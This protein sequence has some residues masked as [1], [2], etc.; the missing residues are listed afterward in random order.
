MTGINRFETGDFLIQ[1]AKPVSP[2]AYKRLQCKKSADVSDPLSIL[3]QMMRADRPR[4]KTV[5]ISIQR[6]HVTANNR[7][8]GNFI[9]AVALRKQESNTPR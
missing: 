8:A 2:G 6:I 4:G 3:N 1:Q 9:C 7:V 5:S